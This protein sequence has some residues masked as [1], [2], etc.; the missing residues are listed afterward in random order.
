MDYYLK[1]MKAVPPPSHYNLKDCFNQ[2]DN[3]KR[4][5]SNKIDKNLIKY[6]YLERIQ[7]EQKNRKRPAP[8]EY[9]LNKTDG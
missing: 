1:V 6:T 4:G 3:K 9:N 7:I 2:E 5:K 8:G